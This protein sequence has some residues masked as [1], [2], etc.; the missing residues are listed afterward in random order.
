MHQGQIA[1]QTLTPEKIEALL[2][3]RREARASRD[4]QRADDIRK[5]L[6]ENNV[7]I[8]DAPD[9]TSWKYTH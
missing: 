3:E 5:L 9:G 4:F 1:E 6:A 7:E 2:V 8:K